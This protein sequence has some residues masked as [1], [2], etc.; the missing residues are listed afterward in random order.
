MLFCPDSGQKIIDS[1]CQKEKSRNQ[2][3][4]K[5]KKEKLR[6]KQETQCNRCKIDFMLIVKY[7]FRNLI[8][9][10]INTKDCC[11]IDPKQQLGIMTYK[12]QYILIYQK[13]DL[14]GNTCRYNAPYSSSGKISMMHRNRC[15]MHRQCIVS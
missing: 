5:C 14:M 4:C 15:F 10:I 13:S 2:S 7:L 6:Q 3:V 12:S 11:K 8:H 1:C 9:K